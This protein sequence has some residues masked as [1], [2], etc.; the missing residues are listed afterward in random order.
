M[1]SNLGQATRYCGWDCSWLPRPFQSNACIIPHLGQDNFIPNLFQFFINLSP[2]IWGF[3]AELLTASQST[4][5][6]ES[7]PLQFGLIF[8]KNITE[9]SLVCIVCVQNTGLL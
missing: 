5:L 7:S 2:D 4:P 6:Q 9:M 1:G 8:R 3:V